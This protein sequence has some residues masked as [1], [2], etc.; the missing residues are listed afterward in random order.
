MATALLTPPTEAIVPQ[1]SNTQAPPSIE[2]LQQQQE[3]RPARVAS[4]TAPSPTP[5][6]KKMYPNH[7]MRRRRLLLKAHS[8][9]G[10]KDQQRPHA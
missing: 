2:R 10:K 7:Q 4:K 8:N 9:K 1:P 3:E 5:S 6:P